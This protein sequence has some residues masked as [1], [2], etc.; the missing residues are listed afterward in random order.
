MP[1]EMPSGQANSF[2]DAIR[3]LFHELE[4]YH[5]LILELVIWI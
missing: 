1:R 2:K 4:K 5:K 3:R